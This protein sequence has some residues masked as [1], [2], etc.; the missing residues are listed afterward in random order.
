M[1]RYFEIL[2]TAGLLKR[3]FRSLYSTPLYTLLLH[4][5]SNVCIIVAAKQHNIPQSQDENVI[6]LG[7]RQDTDSRMGTSH[8]HR[9]V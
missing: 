1:S 9:T 2:N 5:R 6:V 4:L 8:S 7:Q 3:A